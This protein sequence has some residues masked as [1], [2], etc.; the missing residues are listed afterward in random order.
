MYYF[1]HEAFFTHIIPPYRV[2]PSRDNF[3]S[4]P[5]AMA[6]ILQ[7]AKRARLYGITVKVY[8]I[9]MPEDVSYVQEGFEI[10]PPFAHTIREKY[11]SNASLKFM[12]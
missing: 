6:S 2:S 5:L 8:A 3:W 11:V 4:Q 7:A 10:L 1:L 9:T 12:L